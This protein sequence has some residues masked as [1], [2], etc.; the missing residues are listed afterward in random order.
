MIRACSGHPH[1]PPHSNCRA[2]RGHNL[3]W[4]V[5]RH[6]P[7]PAPSL[8][9]LRWHSLTRTDTHSTM[10]PTQ[11]IFHVLA[12]V[13]NAAGVLT[14]L[15]LIVFLMAGGANAKPAHLKILK[16]LMIATLVVGL[17]SL[18]GSIWSMVAGRP[19][20]GTI[21]AAIPI[22]TILVWLEF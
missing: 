15:C 21:I 11:F 2:A 18:G 19:G 5:P 22:I 7:N 4:T 16:S 9:A 10:Q 14:T 6:L 1:P 8:I 3:A 12:A 20:L 17:L 13:T